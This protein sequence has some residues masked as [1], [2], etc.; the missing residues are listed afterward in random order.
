M[1]NDNEIYLQGVFVV[2]ILVFLFFV[3]FSY[4]RSRLLYKYYFYE[5]TEN[6]F[7]KEHG[8]IYKKYVSIPYTRIQNIDIYRGVLARILGL[9]GTSYP[10]SQLL[11]RH[12]NRGGE[13]SC[14]IPQGD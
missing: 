8:I 10:N 9:S 14:D 2:W 7:R 4:V 12:Y 13:T 3:I 6:S 5:L 11:S 1:N